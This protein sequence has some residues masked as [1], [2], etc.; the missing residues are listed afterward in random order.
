MAFHNL[1]LLTMREEVAAFFAVI[2]FFRWRFE[3]HVRFEEFHFSEARR[4]A[5]AMWL[6][7]LPSFR[8]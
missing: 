2:V 3:L 5:R 4:N 6:G 8:R 7:S 1:T